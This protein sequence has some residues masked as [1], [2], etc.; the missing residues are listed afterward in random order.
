VIA[1]AALAVAS[2]LALTVASGP[3]LADASLAAACSLDFELLCPEVDPESPREVVVSCLEANR[4]A[5]TESCRAEIDPASVPRPVAPPR[6][7]LAD[8]CRDEFVRLCGH[9]ADRVA[10]AR[11]VRTR[12]ARLSEACR[13][14][15]DA[16]V[17]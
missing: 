6:D 10:F 12:R 7:P 3:A 15:L 9:E 14:A 5:L 8:A 11:C 2:G 13:D 4:D 16:S 17:R 1:R